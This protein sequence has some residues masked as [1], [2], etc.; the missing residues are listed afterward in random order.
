MVF[1]PKLNAEFSFNRPTTN[2]SSI[3]AVESLFSFAAST[4]KSTN[5]GGSNTLTADEKFSI[6]F[7]EYVNN[8][9]P[10][11][12]LDS[13]SMRD[14]IMKH[15]QHTDK[16]TNYAESL[17]VVTKPFVETARDTGVEDFLKTPEGVLAANEAAKAATVEESNAI[18]LGAM[19]SKADLDARIAAQEREKTFTAMMEVALEI[20]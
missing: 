3:S 11:W 4:L 12:K 16:M 13:K 1:D 7:A 8:Q 19:T 15:P 9:P 14:F 10:S 17:G 18:V 6:D 20:A 2:T 5:S